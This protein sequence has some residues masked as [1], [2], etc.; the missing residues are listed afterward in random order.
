MLYG[1]Q[2]QSVNDTRSVLAGIG[3][4]PVVAFGK[5]APV[6]AYVHVADNRGDDDAHLPYRQG[7]VNWDAAL[8]AL[9]S[10]G[11]GGPY[12]I[13]Y[14]ENHGIETQKRFIDDLRRLYSERAAAAA[15]KP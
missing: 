7:T 3:K 4:S 11:F 14:H 10:A 9:L 8:D 6:L 15:P 12:I 1:Q 5:L 2:S 13:E